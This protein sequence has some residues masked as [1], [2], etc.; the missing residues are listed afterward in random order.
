VVL[1]EIIEGGGVGHDLRRRGLIA[2]LS[3]GGQVAVYGRSRP[4]L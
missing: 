3:P 4:G 1:K 2:G